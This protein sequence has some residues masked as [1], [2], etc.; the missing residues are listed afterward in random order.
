[1]DSTIFEYCLNATRLIFDSE[2]VLK[3]FLLSHL[4]PGSP[5]AVIIS[6]ERKSIVK[7]SQS[8][9]TFSEEMDLLRRTYE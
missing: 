9:M 1:M 5:P 6:S 2:E 4:K 7:G 8:P 3:Q